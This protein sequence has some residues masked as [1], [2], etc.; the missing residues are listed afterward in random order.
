MEIMKRKNL[1]LSITFFSVQVLYGVKT[2]KEQ[3]ARAYFTSRPLSEIKEDLES[4][5]LNQEVQELLVPLVITKYKRQLDLQF[6]KILKGH[7]GFVT[8]IAINKNGRYA[9]TGSFDNTVRL[10]DLSTGKTS[11]TLIGHTDVITSVVF[12]QCG[13]YALTGSADKTARLW[14]LSTGETIK[15]LHHTSTV[16]SAAFSPDGTQTLTGC[17][18]TARLWNLSTGET[19][20]IL[21]HPDLVTSVAFSENSK[22]AL[23]KCCDKAAHLWDLTTG[24][25]IQTLEGHTNRVNSVIWGNIARLLD[26]ATGKTIMLKG[27]TDSIYSIAISSDNNYAL[28]GSADNTA[29]LWNL[30]TGQTIKIL[31]G[32]IDRVLL[33]AFSPE[34]NYALTQSYD[35]TTRLWDLAYSTNAISL[36][37]VLDKINSFALEAPCIIM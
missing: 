2:L 21:R 1:V 22:Q 26:R 30:E 29:R 19:I 12:S 24:Q 14:D 6:H 18:N 27:H 32:H 13:N 9:L 36:K 7:V 10:W 15:I 3:A 11:A 20:K 17:K 33:V 31:A 23:T 28:T 16:T 4:N 35:N 37:E 8:V 5:K 34:S 25:P